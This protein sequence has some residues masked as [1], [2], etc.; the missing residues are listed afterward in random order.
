MFAKKLLGTSALV[1]ATALVGAAATQDVNGR[2]YKKLYKPDFQPP[3]KTFPLVWPVLYASIALTSAAVLVPRARERAAQKRRESLGVKYAGPQAD[4]ASDPAHG[5]RRALLL[6]LALN[7]SWS[8]T[9]FRQHDLD[10]AL[11]TATG[12]AVSSTDLARRAGRVHRGLGWA[13]A[14]YAAWCWFATALTS[15]IRTLNN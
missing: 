12:L 10:L 9:F 5:Y 2:W 13:L 11:G 14:P 8:W 4:A 3:A 1:T 7:A 6:N 15:R